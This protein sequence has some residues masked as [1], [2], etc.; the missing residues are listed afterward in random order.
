MGDG[1]GLDEGQRASCATVRSKAVASF[2]ASAGVRTELTVD[3]VFTS[4]SGLADTGI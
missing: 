1:T 2:K 4:P 3:I